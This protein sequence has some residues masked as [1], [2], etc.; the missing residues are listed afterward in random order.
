MRILITGATGFVGSHCIEALAKHRDVIT[1]AACR[2][3]SRLP[4]GFKGESRIGDLRDVNYLDKLMHGI[5]TVVHAAAWTSLWDHREQ[6]DELFLKPSLALI[7]LA[8]RQGVKR[9]IFIST[10]SAA[11]SGDAYDPMSPGIKRNYWPHETNVVRIEDRLREVSSDRFCAIN[12]R[13][14]LFAGTR[15]ALGLLPILVP[16]LKTHL[17]P[18]VNGGKTGMTITDG[19]DIGHAIELASTTPELSG[20]QSFNILGPE[21]P[22]VREVIDYLYQQY[23][24]PRPHFSVPFPVAFAFA[25]L[26]EKLNPLLPWEPLVTR[27]IIHL[28]EETNADNERASRLLGYQ[29]KHQWREAIDIQMAEMAKHQSKAMSMAR[30]LPGGSGH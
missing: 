5:D 12:L 25:W 26:M 11:A 22:R 29:P 17:V 7:D 27:S 16:R 21:V 20:Y 4:S 2:D 10:V 13:L 18:W 1:I 9:F 15:Y 28:L 30:P 24:L 14:G 8:R 6:S 23:G 19:R 3:P